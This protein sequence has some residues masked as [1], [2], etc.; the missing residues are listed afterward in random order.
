M[1]P[2]MIIDSSLPSNRYTPD[3]VCPRYH[4][5]SQILPGV[6]HLIASESLHF[7]LLGWVLKEYYPRQSLVWCSYF[8]AHRC[9]SVLGNFKQNRLQ[10]F[11]CKS[12]PWALSAEMTGNAKFYFWME[13]S[14]FSA[15]AQDR[16]IC[17][18][19]TFNWVICRRVPI[20]KQILHVGRPHFLQIPPPDVSNAL[21]QLWHFQGIIWFISL[22]SG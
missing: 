17:D 2:L 16:Q 18:S 8:K 9:Q 7:L 22:T 6:W 15:F 1:P 14:F 19:G 12:V 20:P 3:S 4:K 10:V 11:I 21:P 13:V 5:P